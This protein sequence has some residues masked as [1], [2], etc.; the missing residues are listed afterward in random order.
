MENAQKIR[1]ALA[2]ARMSESALARSIGTTPSAL[3]QRMRTDKFTAKELEK[4]AEVLGAKYHSY[5][6]FPD[7]TKV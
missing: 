4:I 3:N 5:F 7:G 2:Y 6:E 1:M